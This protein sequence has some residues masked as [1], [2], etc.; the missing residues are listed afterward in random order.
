M[1][2][3]ATVEIALNLCDPSR[4][5]ITLSPGR[6]GMHSTEV[7]INSTTTLLIDCESRPA[8]LQNSGPASP[9]TNH[10]R[11]VNARPVVATHCPVARSTVLTIGTALE[12]AMGDPQDPLRLAAAGSYTVFSA[13]SP[14]FKGRSGKGGGSCD[15]ILDGCQLNEQS[16]IAIAAGGLSSPARHS[17]KPVR[18]T[19]Q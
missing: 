1:G 17:I 14:G 16:Q 9:V 15:A 18:R 4:G 13:S 6:F 3:P 11:I 19:T 12:A 5:D 8:G 10:F 2:C 7:P